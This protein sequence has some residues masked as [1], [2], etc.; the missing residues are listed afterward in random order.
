MFQF[1]F[2]RL[3]FLFFR[4]RIRKDRTFDFFIDR[5]TEYIVDNVMQATK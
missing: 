5:F 3:L 1:G 4:R 2:V